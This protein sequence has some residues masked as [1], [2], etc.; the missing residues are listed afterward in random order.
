MKLNTMDA[1]EEASSDI[2]TVTISKAEYECLKFKESMFKLYDSYYRFRGKTN[3]SIEVT[4][5]AHR[6]G[7]MYAR[8]YDWT[9]NNALIVAQW[10]GVV[11]V[12]DHFAT[13]I[14]FTK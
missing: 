14:L 2:P 3:I 9:W 7:A 5:C 10:I 6:C 4:S 13:N 1:K 11:G 8:D 12:K